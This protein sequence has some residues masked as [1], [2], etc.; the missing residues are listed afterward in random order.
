[1]YLTVCG[2]YVLQCPVFICVSLRDSK[3]ISDNT[4]EEYEASCVL[5]ASQAL[6]IYDAIF[7]HGYIFDGS[8]L[9]SLILSET[10]GCVCQPLCN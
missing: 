7:R 3:A 10:S 1:M 6:L 8:Y 4:E 2:S 5:K 9:S